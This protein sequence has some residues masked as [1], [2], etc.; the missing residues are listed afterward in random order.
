MVEVAKMHLVRSPLKAVL[1]TAVVVLACNPGTQGVGS[2][3]LFG[4]VLSYTEAASKV[5][6]VIWLL[7][8]SV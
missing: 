5:N 3:A 7:G 8:I 2:G 6:T 4:L 1:C